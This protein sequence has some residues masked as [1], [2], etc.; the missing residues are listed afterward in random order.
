VLRSSNMPAMVDWYT[1]VLNMHV[2]QRN[3]FICFLTYDD[4]HHRLAI[5]NIE[6]LHEPDA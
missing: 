1:T 4:E 6:G 5:V 2:V 3:D